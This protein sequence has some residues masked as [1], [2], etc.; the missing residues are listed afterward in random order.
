MPLTSANLYDLA[1]E[2]LFKPYRQKSVGR[3]SIAIVGV[4]A[5]SGRSFDQFVINDPVAE[6]STLL[7]TLDSQFD[8]IVVL[9]SMGFK[10]STDLALQF[11]QISIVISAD[12]SRSNV[13]P[14]LSGSALVTQTANRGRY[15]GVL[16]VEWNG[17]SWQKRTG[18]RLRELHKK[19]DSLS[20]RLTRLKASPA[21]RGKPSTT[22]DR[23]E[24]ER[25]RIQ[26][27]IIALEATQDN[28]QANHEV[29]FYSNTF[30]PLTRAKRTDPEVTAILKEAREKIKK[31]SRK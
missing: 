29:S 3:L 17:A 5:A 31:A 27:Q 15:L 20:N 4:T 21:Q 19:Y 10:K 9:A 12:N 22:I 26:Q 13:P 2:R 7:P 1:G 11:P 28:G 30:L 6:L 23:L 14:V 18:D 24:V 8:L 25:G 16:T